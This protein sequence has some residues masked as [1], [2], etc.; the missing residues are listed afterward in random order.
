MATLSATPLW[1]RLWRSYEVQLRRRPLLTNAATSAGLWAV[2]DV[3]AQRVQRCPQMDSRRAVLTGAFGGAIVGPLGQ[4]WYT[5]LD[6]MAHAIGAPGTLKFV[7]AKL[8][9]DNLIWTSFYIGLF[10][11][12]ASVAIE[13]TGVSGACQK[14]QHEF[15][16][17][18]AA[19]AIM[20]PP[21][22]A[23]VFSRVPVTHQLLAVNITTVFDVA[24]LSWV[25]SAGFDEVFGSFYKNLGSNSSKAGAV[26]KPSKSAV[27]LQVASRSARQPQLMHCLSADTR[28]N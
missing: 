14:L 7:L 23:L 11:A 2:G 15:L 1:R 28:S 13:Q 17:T 9:A 16:P 8:A 19:E 22:M 3:L 4:A 12:F 21:I 18:Y 25:N 27:D 26:S 6:R 20:W 5:W 10:M 24:F